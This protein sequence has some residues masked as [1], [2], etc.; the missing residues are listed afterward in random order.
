MRKYV[1]FF[2]H[3]ICLGVFF[4]VLSYIPYPACCCAEI[5]RSHTRYN[6]KI[7]LHLFTY[8]LVLCGVTIRFLKD[9]SILD[10]AAEKK[11]KLLI[12]GVDSVFLFSEPAD[13][14]KCKSVLTIG[15]CVIGKCVLSWCK[16]EKENHPRY[17]GVGKIRESLC[18]TFLDRYKLRRERDILKENYLLVD[19]QHDF[20]IRKKSDL[21]LNAL[22]NSCVNLYS[23]IMGNVNFNQKIQQQKIGCCPYIF[24]TIIYGLSFIQKSLI[25]DDA[26]K[27]IMIF[28][29]SLDKFSIFKIST[30]WVQHFNQNKLE[31]IFDLMLGSF[32]Q[33]FSPKV[34]NFKLH[35]LKNM[36]KGWKKYIYIYIFEVLGMWKNWVSGLALLLDNKKMF[37]IYKKGNKNIEE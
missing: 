1:G 3:I 15:T 12:P 9:S 23:K 36:K 11:K 17:F 21:S 14:R 4:F 10:N 5:A 6:I 18:C 13:N 28:F 26:I 2:F 19:N 24:Y 31:S 8:V 29:N 33:P 34:E 37:Q 35:A 30:K 32:C 27:S 25:L 16:K 7:K 22:L 20:S